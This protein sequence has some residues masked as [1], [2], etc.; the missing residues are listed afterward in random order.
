MDKGA[1]EREK[2]LEVK[3]T[4]KR[5]KRQRTPLH[6]PPL[7]QVVATEPNVIPLPDASS[8]A[9]PLSGSIHVILGNESNISFKDR[10]PNHLNGQNPMSL[11]DVG[12]STTVYNSIPPSDSNF[13]QDG[14]NLHLAISGNHDSATKES[15]HLLP[16]STSSEFSTGAPSSRPVWSYGRG[17][18][19]G[20]E[21][22]STGND[23]ESETGAQAFAASRESSLALSYT[24]DSQ[25]TDDY[26]RST[27]DALIGASQN[28]QIQ[29]LS[30]VDTSCSNGSNSSILC[31]DT[32]DVLFMYYLDKV[33]H[34][35]YPFYHS[36][37]RQGRTWLFSILKRVN[38]AYHATLAVSERYYLSMPLSSKHA[39]GSPTFLTSNYRHYDMA[40]REMR[41]GMQNS[42]MWC[43]TLGLVR[44]VEALTCIIQLIFWE[45]RRFRQWI[46]NDANDT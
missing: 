5:R 30:A 41:L 46:G 33:F 29:S 28:H 40:L 38:S 20:L 11:Y 45:V 17:A 16:N 18:S 7:S 31:G 23:V 39:S 34:I 4:I 43:G 36:S 37:E 10:S 15:I 27:Y 12:W 1:L 8:G 25:L 19:I 2:A 35:Q 9:F 22:D 13:H 14:L 32:E 6:L 21:S 42:H 44:S 26:F 24:D 3:E